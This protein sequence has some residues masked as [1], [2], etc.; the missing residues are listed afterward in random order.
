MVLGKRLKNISGRAF[1]RLKKGTMTKRKGKIIVVALL[2]AL[3][4]PAA[5]V[6]ARSI[7]K[8]GENINIAENERVDRAIS[9]GGQITVS[10][11][12][13]NNVV[14][15]GGPIVLTGSA[16]VRG[17]VICIGGVVVR[18][19][20]ALVF[21]K[22]TEVNAGNILPAVASVFYEDTD[23]WSW[24]TNIIGFFLLVLLFTLAL[25][26][27]FL[28]PRPL[29]AIIEAIRDNKAGAFF[30]GL[31]GAL[32]IAP[33]FMLL[34]LSVVGIP[35][36]PLA[37]SAILLAFMAGFIAVSALLGQFVLSNTFRRPA[38]LVPATLLGLILWWIIGWTPF[39]A[40]MLIKAAVV[41][42]GFGGVLLTVCGG[43]RKK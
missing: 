23:E 19:S 8:I 6:D 24:L 12:V 41:T 36:I 39:Y 42:A 22:I 15:L 10:G 32:L 14:I 20:G 11:M 13:E 43:G 29:N 7:I 17:N 33:F 28:F 37:F 31:A 3:F 4:F 5:P 21:G 30:W 18:G 9:V 40:G 1:S 27:A 25:I 38:S 35:L 26:T 16:V 2:V 34:V